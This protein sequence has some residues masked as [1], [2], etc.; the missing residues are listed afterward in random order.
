MMGT[1]HGFDLQGH[2]GARGLMPENTLPAFAKALSIGVNTL[3]LDVGITKDNHV[4][5]FHNPHLEP[6]IARE[7]D[8]QWVSKN[9]PAIHSLTLSELK[10]YDVGRLNPDTKYGKRYPDQQSVD[11]TRVPTLAEVFELINKAE[12]ANVR[13][14]IESKISPNEP[15]LSPLPEAFASAVLDVVKRYNMEDR[16]TIQSFDWRTV[17][18]VQRQAPNIVTS[19]LTVSQSWFDTVQAGQPGPSPWMAG[20]DVDNYNGSIPHA[21]KAAGGKIWSS[22]H[23]EVTS[24][25]IK[26]AHN[27][28][29]LVKVWTVNERA[30]M[31][32]LIDMDVD[33]IITDYPDVLRA[34]L[35]DRD[36]PLPEP[37]P[38]SP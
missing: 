28:G 3:E 1:A 7:P 37:T 14:N 25:N 23:K 21:I 13:F 35:S 34:V 26:A 33:G 32:R 15:D 36:M 16:V 17:Q 6:E 29:L 9:R 2:R 18:N 22:Y 5:V 31:S 19:Y 10:A 38:V 11:G 12:N 4:V 27:L 30:D 24:E 20:F 8:G